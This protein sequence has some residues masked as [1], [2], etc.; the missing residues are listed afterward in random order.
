MKILSNNMYLLLIDEEAEIKENT[1]TFKEGFNGDWF[2]CSKY[3]SIQRIGDITEFD[4]KIIAYYPLTKEAKELDLPLLP[5]FKSEYTV[6]QI[7]D[8][9]VNICKA[10]YPQFEEWVEYKEV[11][12]FKAS[13][14]S[15]KQFS[16]EDMQK[17]IEMAQQ[18]SWDEGG[19]LGLE[20]KP[21]EII[22]SL[23][24]QQLPKEFIPDYEEI[25]VDRFIP[26]MPINILKTIINSEGKEEL[27]GTYKY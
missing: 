2:W 26:K 15:D 14:Q 13:R 3:N 24:T 10:T 12:K 5:N 11:E 19:Y 21:E 16:L 27:V 17:A 9:L 6:F 25:E 8:M 23:S 22:Q 1:N 20:H 4:F 7:I 18:E